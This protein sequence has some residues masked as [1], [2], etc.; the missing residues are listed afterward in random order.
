MRK[1]YEACHGVTAIVTAKH[2]T[3]VTTLPPK[4]RALKHFVTVSRLNTLHITFVF[5]STL[6]YFFSNNNRDFSFDTVTNSFKPL[7]YGLFYV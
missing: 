4:I 5:I 1:F 6:F 7:F 3:A 2:I